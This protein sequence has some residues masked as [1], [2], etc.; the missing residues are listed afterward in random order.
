VSL[1]LAAGE[2]PGAKLEAATTDVPESM[3]VGDAVKPDASLA[4]GSA[5]PD[6]SVGPDDAVA[7]AGATVT[8][9]A[10]VGA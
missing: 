6:A 2:A 7:A 3:A 4:P 9:G 1:E 5:E 10:S 8:P